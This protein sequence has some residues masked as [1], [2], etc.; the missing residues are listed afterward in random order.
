MAFRRKKTKQDPS[1]SKKPQKTPEYWIA[2]YNKKLKGATRM[3][4]ENILKELRIAIRDRWIIGD[5]KNLFLYQNVIPEFREGSRKKWIV[6]CNICENYFGKTDVQVDHVKGEHSL[7]TPED[8]WPYVVSIMGVDLSE[9][10]ILCKECHIIKTYAERYGHS[11]EIA[12]CILEAKR[13]SDSKEDVG[14]LLAEGF[15][16]ASSIPKRKEQI[17]QILMERRGLTNDK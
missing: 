13:L 6:Q 10:Q 12:S 8:I 7:K 3:S 14:W 1:E 17:T 2:H 16:P 9:L 11:F 5:I 4:E 15:T